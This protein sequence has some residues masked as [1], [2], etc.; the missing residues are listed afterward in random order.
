MVSFLR[1]EIKFFD[2]F[3]FIYSL[4]FS[5]ITEKQVQTYSLS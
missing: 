3:L 5:G 2:T 1:L 4:D